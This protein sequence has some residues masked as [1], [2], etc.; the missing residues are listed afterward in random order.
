MSKTVFKPNKFI[1]MIV[2]KL[3]LRKIT[4][5]SMLKK[6]LTEEEI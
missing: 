1:K 4:I 6:F 3:K 2:T 5:D